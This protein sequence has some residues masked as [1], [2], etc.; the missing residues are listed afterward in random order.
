MITVSKEKAQEML[1]T[2][3]DFYERNNI[4]P[5]YQSLKAAEKLVETGEL[6]FNGQDYKV[7]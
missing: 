7:E 2:S 6:T 4:F 3:Q 1:K 5:N